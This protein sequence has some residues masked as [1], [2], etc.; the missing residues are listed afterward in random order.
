MGWHGQQLKITVGLVAHCFRVQ[1]NVT[2][3]YIRFDLFSEARPIVFLT[4]Q[5]FCFI[6]T[7][8]AGQKV[9]MVPTD[10]FRLNDFWHKK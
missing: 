1:T 9:V 7:E 4:N 10:D 8:M 6:D 5:L 3:F 2:A